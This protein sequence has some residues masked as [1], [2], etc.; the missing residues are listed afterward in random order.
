VN[1]LE[2]RDAYKQYR[3]EV[4]VVLIDGKKAFKYHL[5]E[6]EFL[7]RIGGNSRHGA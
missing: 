7:R 1:I 2:D 3:E 6:Q 4:P 5:D